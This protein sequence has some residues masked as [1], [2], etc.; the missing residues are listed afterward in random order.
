MSNQPLSSRADPKQNL[1][2]R[3]LSLVILEAVVLGGRRTREATRS[4]M[5]AMRDSTSR[6]F[7]ALGI[8]TCRSYNDSWC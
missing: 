5:V 6:L 2:D 4:R 3:L 7:F 8:E 1:I